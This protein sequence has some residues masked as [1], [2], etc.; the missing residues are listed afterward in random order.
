[1]T[2]TSGSWTRLL[3]SDK[4]QRSSHILSVV[5]GKAYVFGG[6][7]LPRQPR[8][9]HVYA[10]DVNCRGLF[11]F[12]FIIREWKAKNFAFRCT[13]ARTGRRHRVVSLSSRWHGICYAG[14]QSIFV[15][16]AW[17]RGHGTSRRAGRGLGIESLD[18]G[19]D[20]AFAIRSFKTFS[21]SSELPLLCKQ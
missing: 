9:N 16:R 18:Y 17:G 13:V 6:E 8:D 5:G 11:Y 12:C 2:T 1:M 4:L 21:A 19:L 3:A 14:W 10:L 7:L 20:A 15:L